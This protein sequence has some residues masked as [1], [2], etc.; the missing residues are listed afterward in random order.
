[1]K[2]KL[3]LYVLILFIFT[4]ITNAINS[5][6]QDD[7]KILWTS[8][9]KL[10]WADF[11]GIVPATTEPFV[12]AITCYSIKVKYDFT[13]DGVLNY[14]I[15]NYFFKN[16]SWTITSENSVLAH[17]QLHFD[18]AELYARK[19]RKSFDSL[20]IKKNYDIETFK[21]IY[22]SKIKK[23]D[24]YQS[25]YD[26]EVTGNTINQKKWNKKIN[27]ELLKLKKYEYIPEE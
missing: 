5:K 20:K 23:C 17:E 16:E 26:S 7:N 21:E 14:K 11:K 27:C 13:D 9:R 8:E 19:I 12:V 1:M 15:E 3:I 10:I 2:K 4:S 18:I 6:I 24:D 25:L 22:H